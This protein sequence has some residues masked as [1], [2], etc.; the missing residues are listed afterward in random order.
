M[1]LDESLEAAKRNEQS[2]QL[3][4]AI[5]MYE[6]CLMLDPTHR[7][8]ILSLSRL[9]L[10]TGKPIQSIELLITK[11]WSGDKDF[12]VQLSNTYMTLNQFD[13]AE[14]VLK[15]AQAK[16]PDSAIL[17]NL[18]VVAIRRNKG[19]E[20]ID[21][22]T[23]SLKLDE[24]NVNT[25]FNLATYYE[26]QNDP[27]K[28][29]EVIGQALTK[30][31][32]M[33]LKEKYIQLL[34][35]LGESSKALELIETELLKN[36]NNLLLQVSKMRTLFHAKRF[37]DCLEWANELEQRP[38]LPPNLKLEILDIKEKCFFYKQEID[39]SLEIIDQLLLQSNGNPS[40]EFRKAYLLAVKRN[41]FEAL[42]ILKQM[43]GRRNLPIQLQQESISLMKSIEIENWKSLVT[44]LID[45]TD[46][47][48]ML[49]Q[50]FTY[51][52]ETRGILLPEEGIQFLKNLVQRYKNKN[53]GFEGLS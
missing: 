20:A 36:P 3:A 48:E 22:F 26:S 43:L 38:D 31:D 47:K 5:L 23:E 39:S 46:S 49:A 37:D 35:N 34:N 24:K 10:M 1:N 42:S 25:W 41:F 50:N 9:Y 16:K 18:G 30:L 19:E 6:Q 2:G 21:Y 51:L 27:R 53:K 28:A 7:D 4:E 17:N 33:E 11:N 44:Y 14:R 40:Y 12:L 8:S 29:K 15:Q 52:L 45:E 32:Q 13:E